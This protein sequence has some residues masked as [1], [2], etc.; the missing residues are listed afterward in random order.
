[1]AFLDIYRREADGSFTWVAGTCS[2]KAARVIIKAAASS[3]TEQYLIWD[4]AAGEKLALRANG[5]WLPSKESQKARMGEAASSFSLRSAR[6][7]M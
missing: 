6:N 2:V 7:F 4:K 1:M 3:P 5:C